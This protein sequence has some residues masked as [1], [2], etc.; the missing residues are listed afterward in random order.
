MV[1]LFANSED[2]DQMPH[3]GSALICQL[4]FLGSPD[5]N[6]LRSL[7]TILEYRF[8]WQQQGKSKKMV[9]TNLLI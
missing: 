7:L 3:T 1:E 5:Y 6:G 4:P 9:P 2:P 8:T